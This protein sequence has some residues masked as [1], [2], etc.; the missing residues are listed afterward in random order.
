MQLNCGFCGKDGRRSR[1]QPRSRNRSGFAMGV[2]YPPARGCRQHL[3]AGFGGDVHVCGQ[4]L[5]GLKTPNW[6]T[7]LFSAASILDRA[8]DQFSADAD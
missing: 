7:E 5:Y 4:V 8:L 3:G 6:Y 2:F 1:V